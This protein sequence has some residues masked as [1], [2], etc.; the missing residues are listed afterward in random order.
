MCPDDRA[1]RLVRTAWYAVASGW[2][3]AGSR[4]VVNRMIALH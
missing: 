2:M 3:A 4:L 1:L